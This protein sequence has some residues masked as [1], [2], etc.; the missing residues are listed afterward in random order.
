MAAA[1]GDGTVAVHKSTN[2]YGKLTVQSAELVSTQSCPILIHIAQIPRSPLY[3]LFSLE[4]SL[5]PQDRLVEPF[6][7]ANR[8]QAMQVML[9][10]HCRIMNHELRLPTKTPCSTSTQYDLEALLHQP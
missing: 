6:E 10:T 5:F 8:I 1:R 9:P 3:S 2:I 7:E 4:Q